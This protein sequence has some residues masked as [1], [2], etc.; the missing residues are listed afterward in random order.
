MDPDVLEGSGNTE[1]SSHPVIT[2][3]L[4][5]AEGGYERGGDD[6]R[7]GAARNRS[8]ASTNRDT[9]VPLWNSTVLP[10]VDVALLV[11]LLASSTPRLLS[12]LSIV[13][14]YPAGF[15]LLVSALTRAGN[16]VAVR[17]VLR[18]GWDGAGAVVAGGM[19]VEVAVRVWLYTAG[20]VFD[21]LLV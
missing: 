4:M 1:D 16:V 7:V 21:I 9:K 2:D 12:L 15:F 18:C 20:V 14:A 19:A 17:A 8:I 3:G 5:V 10:A 13:W 6:H 11:G